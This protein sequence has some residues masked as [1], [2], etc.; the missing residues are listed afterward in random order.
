[1]SVI[2]VTVPLP[3]GVSPAASAK[4]QALAHLAPVGALFGLV[5]VTR[6]LEALPASDGLQAGAGEDVGKKEKL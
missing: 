6:E 3:A 4:T 5:D 2:S 1:V